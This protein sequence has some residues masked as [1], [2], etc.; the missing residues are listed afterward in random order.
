MGKKSE[1]VLH[2]KSAAAD[3]YLPSWPLDMTASGLSSTLT[4]FSAFSLQGEKGGVGTEQQSNRAG[5]QLLTGDD[6]TETIND[7]GVIL[8]W[9]TL[10]S[11]LPSRTR[12]RRDALT[13][14]LQRLCQVPALV[15]IAV[16]PSTVLALSRNHCQYL[17]LFSPTNWFFQSTSVLQNS[18]LWVLVDTER[19]V[20]AP[21]LPQP[22]HRRAVLVH[23]HVSKAEL[24]SLR[25][26]PGS[27]AEGATGQGWSAWSQTP[28]AQLWSEPVA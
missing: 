27:L 7:P 4:T 12:T 23:I 16:T 17:G 18:P 21:L 14:G 2:L 8:P 13:A 9:D 11:L 10:L 3:T 22:W 24:L 6:T 28:K 25:S 20:K 5:E 15:S 26:E 1:Q 19:A